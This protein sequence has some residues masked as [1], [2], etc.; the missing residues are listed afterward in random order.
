MT[1]RGANVDK[2]QIFWR[3]FEL[4]ENELFDVV[5]YDAHVLDS[6]R[7]ELQKVRDG[8]T[9][10]L[11]NTA[12]TRDLVISADGDKDLF[13]QVISLVKGAPNLRRW[14]FVAFRPRGIFPVEIAIGEKVADSKDVSFSLLDNGEVA[15]IRLF[16]P[17]Y[18]ANDLGWREI[19]YLLLDHALGEYD[20]EQSLPLIKMYSPHEATME[21]RYPLIELPEKFDLLQQK[22]SGRDV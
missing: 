10:E 5:S 7:D 22:L 18:E 3:W 2:V 14:R 16:I 6:L 9:F 17:G 8:L 12:E 21:R 4:H 1:L 15:G 11:G 13:P 20:V 19:G